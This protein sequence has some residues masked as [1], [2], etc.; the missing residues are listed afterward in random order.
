MSEPKRIVLPTIFENMSVN[1]W[2]FT[3]PE[4]VLIDCGEKTEAS[5]EALN[6]GL[7]THGL[8]IQDIKKVIITHAHLDHMGM[9]AKI[10]EH[11]D[12]MI[13]VSEYVY[14]WAINLEKMLDNRTHTIVKVSKANLPASFASEHFSFGYEKLAPYWDEIPKDKLRV[15]SV[16][17]QLEFAGQTWDVVYTPGHCV[18]QT[19]FFQKESGYFFSA[20]MLLKMIPIPIID[21]KVDMP[22]ERVSCLSMQLESYQK[23][24]ALDIKK[25]F[26]GHYEA[27]DKVHQVIEKQIK[28]IQERKVACFEAIDTGQHQFLSIWQNVYGRRINPATFFMI[29]GLL[30]LLMEEGRIKAKEVDGLLEYYKA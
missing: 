3:S 8:R 18:N 7:K 15:F 1:A 30:D 21:P 4:P 24:L 17:D 13:W 25:V 11:S 14:D 22:E 27:F 2:L 26:P 16:E 6:N 5:W 12:A 9:A 28:K 20:D 19:C 23:L 10:A 29:V